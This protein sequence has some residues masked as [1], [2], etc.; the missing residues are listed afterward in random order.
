MF[1]TNLLQETVR[2]KFK[3]VDDKLIKEARL[4]ELAK[5]AADREAIRA[6]ASALAKFTKE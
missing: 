5:M 6:I 3:A 1:T 4:E 2:A